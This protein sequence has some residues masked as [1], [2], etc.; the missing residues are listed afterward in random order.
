[1]FAQALGIR[2]TADAV[3]QGIVDARRVAL[4]ADLQSLA[5]VE[6]DLILDAEL[7]RQLVHPDLLGGQRPSFESVA[8][9]SC[10]V[11]HRDAGCTRRSARPT[12]GRPP[13]VQCRAQR[14]DLVVLNLT[15][16]APGEY[17]TTNSLVKARR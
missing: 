15:V 10:C 5:Q 11:V 3:G 6:H 12:L 4:D 9:V 13:P 2:E 1:L 17:P 8:C 16:Q 7:S 14:A